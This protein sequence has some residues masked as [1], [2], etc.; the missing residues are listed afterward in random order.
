MNQSSLKARLV[1]KLFKWI[2]CARRPLKVDEITEAVAFEPSEKFLDVTKI[3][4]E[5][6]LFESCKGLVVRDP[7]D[8]TVR[9]AHHTVQQ[10]LLSDVSD[11]SADFFCFR[12]HE[13]DAWVGTLCVS[14]LCFSDFETQ[15]TKL[16][17]K[18]K[19]EREGLLESEGP[20]G[21][22]SILGLHKS[23]LQIP[24]RL[25]G[26][27]PA[28][29]APE[30]DYTNHV[31]VPGNPIANASVDIKDKYK[32]LDY[33]IN[34]WE[35]HTRHSLKTESEKAIQDL[36]MY[37]TLPF[38]FRP[39]G[40]NEHF[41]PYGCSSCTK[42]SNA[43]LKTMQLPHISLFNYAT[44]VGNMVLLRPLFA[45]YHGH[46][47]FETFLLACRYGQTEVVKY[48]MEHITYDISE[49]RVVETA[50]KYGHLSTLTYFLDS[51]ILR[52]HRAI[53][54]SQ[55]VYLAAEG[56]HDTVVKTLCDR[57]FSIYERDKSTGWDALEV[58]VY[59][60]HDAV[61]RILLM[62]GLIEKNPWEDEPQE[63]DQWYLKGLTK[64]LHLAVKNGHS[65][66]VRTLF[67]LSTLDQTQKDQDG[68][69]P[70]HKAAKTG[71][72]A[73]VDA[74][75]ENCGGVDKKALLE[76]RTNI[77]EMASSLAASNGHVD[78]LEV[79]RRHGF[80]I[81][82][83][84]NW[85]YNMTEIELAALNGHDTAVRWLLHHGAGVN[86]FTSFT[87]F[88][89]LYSAVING[90]DTTVRLLL[91]SGA[92]ISGYLFEVAARKGH[93]K[94]LQALL[95]YSSSNETRRYVNTALKVA[96]ANG[97]DDVV[98]FLQ[99]V[100]KNRSLKIR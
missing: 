42:S 78:V 38:K 98:Q 67:E 24:Y 43:H 44:Q 86:E 62:A 40:E 73:I 9:F 22:P 63:P 45:H 33:V 93:V 6:L 65:A 89:P 31:T 61:V 28:M 95:L 70:L 55:A 30:I 15:V 49:R 1:Q 94:V 80:S 87:G 10:H 20:L 64:P 8:R 3:P 91:D 81:N 27:K 72:S 75:L 18:R 29:K 17:P 100:L 99:S 26:G 14:Y 82:H 85:Q 83:S 34:H 56:G 79:L 66:I 69:I 46:E 16:P 71:N 58:A 90:H 11:R 41:G 50:A 84:S 4:D 25:L 2:A 59:N 5:V 77:G 52:Q 53:Y 97:M 51:L 76:M 92:I 32:L 19:F 68:E 13:A 37:K 47:G 35:P 96:G 12:F 7:R 57:G 74:L 48:F 21:I 88:G 39:W 23:L 54:L 60:G 36:A